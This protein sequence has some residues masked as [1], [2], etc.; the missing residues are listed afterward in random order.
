MMTIEKVQ[1]AAKNL[2]GVIAETPLIKNENLSEQMAAQVF[3]KEKT[4]NRYVPTNF[5]ERIIRS[6]R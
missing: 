5:G 1:L 2:K 3:L 4:Y 6:A